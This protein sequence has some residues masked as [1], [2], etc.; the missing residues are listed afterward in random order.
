M[1]L[2]IFCRKKLQSILKKK[3]LKYGSIDFVDKALSIF[4]FLRI[5]CLSFLTKISMGIF[6]INLLLLYL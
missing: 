2:H 6:F 1:S 4:V 5:D 3:T